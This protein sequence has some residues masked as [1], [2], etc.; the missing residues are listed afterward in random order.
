MKMSHHLARV[1]IDNVNCGVIRVCIPAGEIR[2]NNITAPGSRIFP[3]LQNWEVV[4]TPAIFY[5]F[6]CLGNAGEYSAVWDSVPY[7]SFVSTV[8]AE[9]SKSIASKE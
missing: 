6:E 5:L 3:D 1:H 4:V 7:I 8:R 9:L 2:R